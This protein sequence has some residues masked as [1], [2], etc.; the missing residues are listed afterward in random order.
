VPVFYWGGSTL[1][2]RRF[3]YELTGKPLPEG[4]IT[5]CCGNRLCVEPTH[6]TEVK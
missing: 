4:N 5:A 3:A 1:S 2:A 6:M